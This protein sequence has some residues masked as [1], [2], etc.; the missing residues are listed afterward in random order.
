M[1]WH[2]PP[3]SRLERLC[4]ASFVANGH[5]VDLYAY[6]EIEGVPAGV[7]IVDA[8]SILSRDRM[9]WHRRTG[10]IA[11][12][13]DWFRYRLLHERGG[14][15]AD[16]DVVCLQPL[17]YA[18]PEIYAW[19]DAHEI[20]N[21]ILGLP[22]GHPLAAWMQ[23]CCEDPNRVLPYDTLSDRFRKWRRRALQ[24][25]RRERT[26]WGEYGP[27][28]FTLAARHLGYASKALPPSEFYPVACENWGELF[29]VGPEPAWLNTSHAVHLWNNML[30]RERGFNKNAQFAADSPYER[31]QRLFT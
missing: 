19:Q 10:S 30:S 15:W 20:N 11:L 9:F 28:G 2:G 23:A 12:F 4:M 16:T 3:L 25:N 27:K 18:Q 21:A 5:P 8:A 26:R 29:S 1:F 6:D 24:G 22:A 17:R 13:A 14:I 31:L 7:R